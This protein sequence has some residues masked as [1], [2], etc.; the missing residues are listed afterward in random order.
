MGRG[1][2]LTRTQEGRIIVL[3]L[4]SRLA[5]LALMA[6][7]DAA[8]PDLASSAQLQ[9]FPCAGASDEG[10]P[11][12]STPLDEMAPWDSVYFVRIAKCGYEN[13]M[14][15]AFFPLLPAVMRYGARLTGE[16]PGPGAG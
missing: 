16:A 3:A 12:R 9:N 10:A 4:A 8:F 15:N 14:I 1:W 6:A 5:V 2:A 13:D 7:A 11:L